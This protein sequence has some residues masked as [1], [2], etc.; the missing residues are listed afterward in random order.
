SLQKKVKRTGI[1]L[2]CYEILVYTATQNTGQR[3]RNE[4]IESD[5][6]GN[7]L[8]LELIAKHNPNIMKKMNAVGYANYTSANIQNE[9]LVC[10]AEMVGTSIIRGQEKE[11]QR[12]SDTRWECRYLAC[13]NLADRLPAVVRAPEEIAGKQIG[14][15]LHLAKAVDLVEALICTFKNY[16]NEQV[17]VFWTTILDITEQCNICT[18]TFL[19][20]K[21]KQSSKL[22]ATCVMFTAGSQAAQNSKLFQK[23]SILPAFG[24]DAK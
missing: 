24:H 21:R 6:K 8:I 1:I 16:R 17:F 22:E 13:H 20:Q 7:F 14:E 4:T 3:G 12:L 15:R 23:R 18:E 2:K 5:R 9:I 10:L 19:K 11:L